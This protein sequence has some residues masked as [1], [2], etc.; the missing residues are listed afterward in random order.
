[1]IKCKELHKHLYSSNNILLASQRVPLSNDP[2]NSFLLRRTAMAGRQ[3]RIVGYGLSDALPNIFPKPIVALRA[4]Q[5]S[6]FAQLGQLWIEPK[7]SAGVAQNLCWVLTSIIN[8]SANWL[9][10]VGGGGAGVFASLTVTPG[11][12][13]LT[14]T[15]TINT[16]GAGT[17]AI[18]VGGTGA[19]T[20]GNA[21]GNTTIPAGNL[22]LT[23]GN[24]VVSAGNI[25]ATLG[26]IAATAGSLSAGTTVT[27]GTG[28]TATLGNITATNGNVVLSTAATFLQL[29]G[30]IKV[31]S[32][33]GAPGNGLAAE[34]GDLYVRTDPAGATSRI[35]VATGAGAWTNI[36]C[37]G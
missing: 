9:A 17:T 33:A 8:N 23:L 10:L 25:T 31:M 14:G 32:G 15:T 37:A 3:Q 28:I 27:A 35:Y 5:T 4:P 19:V 18:G 24:I 6:D 36:T 20:I 7:N 13:S 29:P 30:P 11:P 12:I 1:L 34:A 16:A 22:T 2:E 21:T 26:N